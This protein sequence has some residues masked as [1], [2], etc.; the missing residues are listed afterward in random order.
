MLQSWGDQ[1]YLASAEDIVLNDPYENVFSM[2]SELGVQLQTAPPFL[3]G[4]LK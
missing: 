3:A 2:P 1:I 4:C